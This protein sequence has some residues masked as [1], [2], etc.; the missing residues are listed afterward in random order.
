MTLWRSQSQ[1]GWHLGHCV[2]SWD[3]F[4][5]L[6]EWSV[7]VVVSNVLYGLLLG[8]CVYHLT[9][10][11][12]E[13][14]S[15][16]SLDSLGDMGT[17]CAHQSWLLHCNIKKNTQSSTL[18]FEFRSTNLAASRTVAR[19]PTALGYC[20][21]LITAYRLHFKLSCVVRIVFN[22]IRRHATSLY[23]VT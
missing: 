17:S 14:I 5:E 8:K 1:A 22:E 10:A 4:E 9:V 21:T 6:V 16:S 13:C 7:G 23:I 3:R 12:C 11:D 20:D 19:R 15:G 2:S 18:G